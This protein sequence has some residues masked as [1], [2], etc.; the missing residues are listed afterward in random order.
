MR[1]HALA[2]S[3]LLAA[4]VLLPEFGPAPTPLF[5]ALT[6]GGQGFVLSDCVFVGWGRETAVRLLVVFLLVGILAYALSCAAVATASSHRSFA[7]ASLALISGMALSYF[8]YLHLYFRAVE[9][10]SIRPASSVTTG[11]LL[12]AWLVVTWRLLVAGPPPLSPARHAALA[13]LLAFG[14][15]NLFLSEPKIGTFFG[16]GG[17]PPAPFPRGPFWPSI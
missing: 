10:W 5:V 2:L 15:M 17:L 3:S 12:L 16:K 14:L 6:V 4:S 7:L 11:L 13:S 1:K 9:F 8:V